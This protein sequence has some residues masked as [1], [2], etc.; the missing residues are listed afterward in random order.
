MNRNTICISTNLQFDDRI[1]DR[2]NKNLMAAL[3]ALGLVIQNLE[4]ASTTTEIYSRAY[5]SVKAAESNSQEGLNTPSFVTEGIFLKSGVLKNVEGK[6]CKVNN[7]FLLNPN[8]SSEESNWIGIIYDE[9]IENLEH[10][11]IEYDNRG[12]KI[13]LKKELNQDIKIRMKYLKD[14]IKKI[15]LLGAS[16]LII[17]VKNVHI[18]KEF[19]VKQVFSKPIVLLHGVENV[20][21]IL[22]L[23][24]LRYDLFAK[25][26]RSIPYYSLASTIGTVTLWATCGRSTSGT[27]NEWQGTVCIGRGMISGKAMDEYFSIMTWNA[28]LLLFICS[29]V[30][31][32]IKL[33][34]NGLGFENNDNEMSNE[35]L[36]KNILSQ[37]SIEIYRS[38]GRTSGRKYKKRSDSMDEGGRKFDNPPEQC[39]ICLDMFF[40]LQRLRVLPCKHSFHM[41]CIDRWLLLRQTCPMCKYNILDHVQTTSDA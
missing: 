23:F 22:Q 8:L 11:D 12:N 26:Q 27:F 33:C 34:R 6:L 25:I 18:A 41:N 29:I 2:L 37:M 7:N 24:S 39:V 15:L 16:A 9:D 3:I 31:I 36:A 35:M 17:M 1:A 38:K 19:D 30:Y 20:T 10:D 28:A 14:K 4:F 13:K 32:Y 21:K 5:I 40:P